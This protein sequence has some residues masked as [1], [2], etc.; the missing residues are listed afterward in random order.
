MSKRYWQ[1]LALFTFMAVLLMGCAFGPVAFYMWLILH[2]SSPSLENIAFLLC[3][4]GPVVG[5]ALY[6][7]LNHSFGEFLKGTPAFRSGLKN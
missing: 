7:L 2:D 3:F 1:R 6:R 5:M 4:V